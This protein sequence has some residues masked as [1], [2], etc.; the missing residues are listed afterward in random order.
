MII[1]TTI[2]TPNDMFLAVSC[3]LEGAERDT[4]LARIENRVG[5][6]NGMMSHSVDVARDQF[7]TGR[8]MKRYDRNVRIREIVDFAFN[9]R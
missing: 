3:L 9:W 4:Y 6:L 2:R 7:N 8:G 5:G 1:D